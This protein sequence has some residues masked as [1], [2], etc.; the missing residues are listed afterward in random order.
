MSY[1]SKNT[2]SSG[3][4]YNIVRFVFSCKTKSR[5]LL[6][7]QYA[8]HHIEIVNHDLCKLR[9]PLAFKRDTITSASKV[10]LAYSSVKKKKDIKTGSRWNIVRFVFPVQRKKEKQKLAR[11][12]LCGAQNWDYEPWQRLP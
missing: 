7:Y 10:C 9:G 3:R 8:H 2:I 4:R 11:L 1:L 6:D 5:T 12:P